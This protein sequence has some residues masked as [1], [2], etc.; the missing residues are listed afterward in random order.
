MTDFDSKWQRCVARAREATRCDEA[1]PFGFATRVV[2]AGFSPTAPALE[3]VWKRLALGW[4]ACAVAGLAVCAILE[5]PHLRDS[6]PLNPGVEN[7][8]AQLVWRL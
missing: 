1:A 6:R 2:A 3:S 8:V 5:L 4:L 7:T